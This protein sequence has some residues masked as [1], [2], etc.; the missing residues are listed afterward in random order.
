VNCV[1]CR[2]QVTEL[3]LQVLARTPDWPLKDLSDQYRL[4]GFLIL[5]NTAC[6]VLSKLYAAKRSC[7]FDQ[8]IRAPDLIS[9]WG[10]PSGSTYGR[11]ETFGS[12]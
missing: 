5:L 3:I 7:H 10:S 8:P 6:A 1:N 4:S 11:P 12:F 9:Y 2:L